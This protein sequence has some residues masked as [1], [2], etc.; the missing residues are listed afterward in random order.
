MAKTRRLT[1]LV[2]FLGLLVLGCAKP[3]TNFVTEPYLDEQKAIEKL[4]HDIFD[5]GKRKDI[6]RLESYHLYGPKFTRY[7]DG[8]PWPRQNA[9]QGKKSE[10][11]GFLSADEYSIAFSNLK[12]DVFGDFAVATFDADWSFRAGKVKD[13]A[14]SRSTLVFVKVGGQWK[15]THEH[16]S[17]Y[18]VP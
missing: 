17:K 7:D 16:F 10:R 6:D 2:V 3:M 5:S 9:E 4:V 14:K 15:I 18:G 8:A 12:V 1:R 13:A 11:D